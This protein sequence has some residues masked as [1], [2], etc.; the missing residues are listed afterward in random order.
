MNGKERHENH[1]T[2]SALEEMKIKAEMI[3]NYVL[4]HA[5]AWKNL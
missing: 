4:V 3:K 2:A 1:P 5:T